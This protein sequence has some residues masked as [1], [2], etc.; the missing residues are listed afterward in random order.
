[1]T[2]A[3]ITTLSLSGV[4]LAFLAGL[5]LFVSPCVLPLLPVY[6]SFISGVEVDRLGSERRR[7]LWT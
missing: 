3:Q 7:L 1:M 6:L 5:L 2:A 4:G